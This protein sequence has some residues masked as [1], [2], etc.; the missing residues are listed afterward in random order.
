LTGGDGVD[1][2]A[3]QIDALAWDGNIG[4][5]MP[6]WVIGLDVDAYHGGRDTLAAY[7]ERLG[8]L[9]KTRIS[10]SNRDDGSGI[11]FFIVP[12]GYWWVDLPGIEV[13]QRGYR[14]AMV[15]PSIHP[16]GR[17][18]GWWDEEEEAALPGGEVP[19]V[20][21][22]PALPLPWVV[23]LSR[24]P[25]NTSTR[26][27]TQREYDAFLAAYVTAD[28]A[29]YLSVITTDF[30]AKWK[31][32]YARHPTMQ[33][34]LIWAMEH[35]RAE[36]LHA[37]VALDT[38]RALWAEA[39]VGEPPHRQAPEFNAMVRHAIGKANA[40]TV[41]ELHT[42]HDKAAGPNFNV[43]PTDDEQPD[44]DQ[45]DDDGQ[46]DD[47]DEP[48][49]LLTW[50]RAPDPFIV[51]RV[52]WLIEGLWCDGTHGEL[53][54]EE[55]TLKSTLSTI[56]DVGLA[57]GVPVLGEFP[58]PEAQR[59]LHLAGEGGETGYW[60]RIGRV[61]DAYGITVDQVRDN[62]LVTFNTASISNPILVNEVEEQLQSF[63][64]ALTH[65]DP[66]Y[67]YSP[68]GVD[69]RQLVEVGAALDTFGSLCTRFGST[70]LINNHFNQTGSGNGLTRITGAGHA[71][72]VDS[73]LLASHRQPADVPNG[74]FRLRLEVGSRQ[75]G[76]TSWEVDLDLGKFDPSVGLHIGAI[77]W[78]VR[79]ATTTTPTQQ[80]AYDDKI[81]QAKVD[82][83]AV[84]KKRRKPFQQTEL[85]DATA[86]T[87]DVKRAAFREM[88]ESGAFAVVG[89]VRVAAGRGTRP[90]DIYQ[91]TG[92]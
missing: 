90:V 32:G 33:H 28:S 75:W 53:A 17:E 15:W 89:Q 83:L 46:R 2:T 1:L 40:K 7:S 62:L 56:I 14:Y 9:P 12:A 19:D 63:V 91:W 37:R 68:R 52:E 39:M 18:Y 77:R 55:K 22:L 34:D 24:D 20:D 51:P 85:I 92:P 79:P 60:T 67:A 29:S 70:L 54:G 3:E 45:A 88:V 64:P 71:E 44:R 41:D 11:F 10:H 42:L 21:D 61:C 81:A 65:L 8:P 43:P 23:E 86:G 76:G 59:V 49:R 48:R 72:W 87:K 6:P 47:G 4:V 5:R 16:E 73:W 13:I 50:K 25:A 78:A 30:R 69:T 58:V 82:L 35:A 74:R 66:Y 38:L 57:A 31:Q 27:A 36:V 26:A 84:A 80:S